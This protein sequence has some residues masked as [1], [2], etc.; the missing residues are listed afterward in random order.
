MLRFRVDAELR[1]PFGHVAVVGLEAELLRHLE[2]AGSVG[3]SGVGKQAKP[4]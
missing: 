2:G 3:I 1:H 4:P